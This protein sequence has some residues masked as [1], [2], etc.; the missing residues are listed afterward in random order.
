M[1]LS[2]KLRQSVGS[3]SL[4]CEL[5]VVFCTESIFLHVVAAQILQVIAVASAS[6]A[7]KQCEVKMF[8]T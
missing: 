3:S 4:T 1:L 2:S 6:L 8:P 7:S 5:P